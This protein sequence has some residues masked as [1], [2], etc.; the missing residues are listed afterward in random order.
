MDFPAH[1]QILSGFV[2]GF[3]GSKVFCLNDSTMNTLDVPLSAP[4]YQYIDK[5]MY[6]DA[7]NIACL[8][9][10]EGD[11]EDLA[12]SSLEHLEFEVARLSFIKLQDYPFLEFIQELQDL[13][14]KGEYWR[15]IF[16]PPIIYSVCFFQVIIL[17]N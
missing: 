15:S 17:A 13:Q 14:Q 9:I 4:M 1:V 12:H 5:K 7:Y 10:T 6:N 16:S 3:M 11:W 8:G 2:V